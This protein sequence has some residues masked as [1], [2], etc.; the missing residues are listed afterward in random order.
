[1]R[2]GGVDQSGAMGCGQCRS[3]PRGIIG[4]T[5]DRHIGFGQ[6]RFARGGI[7]A[8]G[9]VNLDQ[10]DIVTGFQTLA[11][12]KP[13]RTRLAVNKNLMRH[14]VALSKKTGL[15]IKAPLMIGNKAFALPGRPT[16]RPDAFN[17]AKLPRLWIALVRNTS[18]W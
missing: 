12:L 13:C 4:Q 2:C 14:A 17:A 11:D 15:F 6:R 18:Y 10:R 16:I 9:R 7:F 1:M 3:F 5:Q 8:Q